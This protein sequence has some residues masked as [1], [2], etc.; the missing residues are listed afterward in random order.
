VKTSVFHGNNTLGMQPIRKQGRRH[1]HVLQLVKLGVAEG[2]VVAIGECGLDYDRLQFCEKDVQRR[3]FDRQFELAEESGLPMLLHSR[4]AAED[5]A[6]ILKAN[7]TKFS[8]A[9]VPRILRHTIL[10]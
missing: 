1:V 3:W 8:G 2:K 9:S 6:S 5:F 4:A 7:G 10:S